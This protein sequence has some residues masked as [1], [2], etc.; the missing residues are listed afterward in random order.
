M[1]GPGVPVGMTDEAARTVD[2]APTLAA[3]AEVPFPDGLD[4][5]PL[6]VPAR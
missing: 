1:A 4:G 3:L 2:M 6:I 5:R